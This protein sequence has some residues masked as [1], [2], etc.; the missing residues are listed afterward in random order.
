MNTKACSTLQQI[1]LD[2]NFHRYALID[3]YTY[4]RDT[5]FYIRGRLI[6]F[7]LTYTIFPAM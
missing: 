3:F 1:D 6:S 4:P 5:S 2:G 7:E